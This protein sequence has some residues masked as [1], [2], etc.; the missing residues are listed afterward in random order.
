[1]SKATFIEVILPLAIPNTYTYAVPFEWHDQLA[2]GKRVLVQ[3][4]KRKFYTALI[5]EIHHRQP[6]DYQAKL[7]D[8]I[9]DDKILV[10]SQQLNLWKWISAYYACTL[11]EVYTIA[12]P[13]AFK[14]SSETIFIALEPESFDFNQLSAEALTLY[15]ALLHN[16][17]L[18]V[19]DIQDILEKKSIYPIV[20]QL[21]HHR[22]CVVKET[23]QE[24]YK[25]KT[26]A[27]IR[28]S[29]RF[30]DETQLQALFTQLEKL[31]KQTAVLLHYLQ[32]APKYQWI[33]KSELSKVEHL[34]QS[35]LKTLIK[36]EIFEVEQKTVSR[37]LT[38]QLDEIAFTSLNEEQTIAVDLIK[39]IFEQKQVAVLEGVT[40]SG[41]THVYIKLIEEVLAKNQQVLY[42]LPEIA[43]TAQ[44]VVRLQKYFGNQI[45]VYH[46][47]FNDQERVELYESVLQ[48]KIKIVLAARSGI[49]LPFQHLG[50]I[51]VDEEHE[52][53][54]KQF[55]PAPRYHARDTAIVLSQIW[56]ANILL[57]SAT[58]SLETQYNIDQ[59]K[60]KLA[61]LTKR[62]GNAQLPAIELID[63]LRLRQQKKM[64]G[65]FSEQLKKA[66]QDALAKKE[67]IILFQNRRGFANYANCNVCNWIPYCPNCDVSL[68]YHKFFNKL[69]CHYCG[70]Q[71]AM[72]KQCKACGSSDMQIKGF[73]TEQIEDEAS[74]L[75]PEAKIA[76]MDIDTTR[77]KRGHEDIIFQFQQGEIDILIGT[78]MVTKG[79]DFDHVSVVG[80]ILADQLF[81]IPDF[82]ANERAFQLL[83]Q[84]A[85]R[86]GRKEKKGTVYIQTNSIDHPILSYVK[87][88]QK[89]SF[90]FEEIQTRKQYLYPP[91]SSLI[92]ITIKHKRPEDLRDAANRMA[93]ALRKTA[94]KHV[95]G[96]ATPFVSKVRNYYLRQIIIKA[97]KSKASLIIL[98]NK[99]QLIS[100]EVQSKHRQV[101]I[102]TEVDA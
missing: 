89:E 2:I 41:K 80:I 99:I 19:R 13:S 74:I 50:L 88:Q 93:T 9:L 97:P 38:E 21:M 58:L 43:L 14:L 85:G 95:L 37:I 20:N 8:E 31:E 53:S 27:F 72:L 18:G 26:L 32:K 49:F 17:S 90:Y 25:P 36:N 34:S 5:V 6:Q 78:Q 83:S 45:A 61:R 73:G 28:L 48:N 64:H 69:M 71:T 102:V 35:S 33:A 12:L 24:K 94:A 77:T 100:Q 57:G 66:I 86:A 76:R 79:L 60:Y 65:L 10:T 42:L 68:T 29:N 4:G 59:G 91:F 44:L 62:Y 47:K 30:K 51:I 67:Q 54:Y 82:R 84:V 96:P 98:K 55:D 15:Q 22:L 39:S 70:H 7:I 63:V 46:S 87:N 3:F 16:D 40:G 101:I 1:M 23:V 75:F 81:S 52:R 92:Q 11:G 56:Q